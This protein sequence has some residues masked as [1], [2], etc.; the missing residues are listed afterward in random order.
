MDDALVAASASQSIRHFVNR[1]INTVTN[2]SLY[3]VPG[4]FFHGREPIIPRMSEGLLRE[5][6]I[7]EDEAPVFVYYLKR[8]IELD[9]DNHGPA[10]KTIIKHVT[11]NRPNELRQL[12]LA[13]LDAMNDRIGFL[14]D[15][16][17][18][19]SQDRP[20]YSSSTI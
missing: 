17:L 18:A 1:M 3:R 11:Q 8:H 7:D 14:D 20:A 12:Y 16:I 15:L 2:G 19:M 10:A 9:G 6:H 4:S 5:R 13:A